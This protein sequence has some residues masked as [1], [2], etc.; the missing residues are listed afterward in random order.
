MLLYTEEI[1]NGKAI[2]YAIEKGSIHI[3]NDSEFN[4]LIK[5]KLS[6]SVIVAKIM[7]NKYNNKY[8]K[9]NASTGSLALE[10][11][12]H[13]YP[14]RFAKKNINRKIYKPLKTTLSK[15]L[16]HT[17]IIDMGEQ[18]KERFILNQAGKVIDLF[19]KNKEI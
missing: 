17:D 12:G 7:L 2:K 4:N 18:D 8:G 3:V 6:F 9:F 13:V 11:L 16:S 5:D 1:I 14:D 19:I 10:I 15:I